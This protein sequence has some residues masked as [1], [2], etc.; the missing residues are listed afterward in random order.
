MK[1]AK[2]AM[3]R[4]GLMLLLL[5]HALFFPDSVMA[6]PSRIKDIAMVVGQGR[7]KLLG[8]GIV[9]G[10]EG[11]GDSQASVLTLRSIANML[12]EFG[13]TVNTNELAAKNLAAVI[14]TAELPATVAVGST[15]DVTVSSMADAKSLQGGT[16]LLT[17]LRAADNNIYALAQGPISTGGFVVETRGGDK[18][19][20][21]HPTVGRVPNGA[22]VVK[23][24]TAALAQDEV[25]LSLL[26]P[27][28]TTA[29]RVAA[30]I[31]ASQGALVA[32]ACDNA[33]VRVKVPVE[34][35][36][37]LPQFIAHIENLY[38]EPAAAARVV[39]N[40]RTG[41]V[42][43]GQHVRIMPV[44][45]CHGSLTVRVRSET[46]VSQPPP[47]VLIGPGVLTP[48]PAQVNGAPKANNAAENSAPPSSAGAGS[49]PSAMSPPDE[50]AS[51]PAGL[52]PASPEKSNETNNVLQSAEG[53]G[54][55]AAS[56]SAAV[57]RASAGR[58]SPAGGR[59]GRTVVVQQD[60]LRVQEEGG[61][62][63]LIPEQA[64]LQDLVAALNMLGVKPRDLIAIIQALQQ[65]QALQAELILF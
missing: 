32:Q 18:A 31:N 28:Y 33:T 62:L 59:E 35:Q 8:Y 60:E 48:A 20:K 2:Q 25:L 14:V 24:L 39:I 57:S 49:A 29:I 3:K 56:S 40:E 47:E 41:T 44:A 64:T 42:V 27:D 54:G 52:S 37:A 19:Q 21:N 55:A 34:A 10:L 50:A 61:H 43:I 58:R 11:T 16:L 15:I 4:M 9:A 26:Q 38:V 45:I 36:A 51:K 5:S 1:A 13:V 65:A 22:S 53:G 12:R 6:S 23:P 46:Q 30:A 63:A 17:P 7:H